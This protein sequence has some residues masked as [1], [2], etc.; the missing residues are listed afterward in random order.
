MKLTCAQMDVLIT[1]YI[2]GDL[3]RTLKSEV[4]NHLKTCSSCR[5]KYDIIKTMLFDIKSSLNDESIATS[6][7]NKYGTKTTS[8]QYRVF[9]NDLSAY[10]DNELP[11]EENIKIKKLTINNAHARK[12]LENS[13]NIRRLMNA[14]FRKTKEENKLD[15]AKNILSQLDI[16][17]E[18]SLLNIHPII[19]WTMI[20]CF[21]SL[22]ALAISLFIFGL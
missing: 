8:Q 10:I 9:K 20:F 11:Q 5:A 6:T 1:F 3:S 15:F 2:E 17:Q 19:K 7:C 14:S 18:A 12:E 4:E 21:G 13:Y 16:E 22:T